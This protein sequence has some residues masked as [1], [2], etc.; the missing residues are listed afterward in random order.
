MVKYEIQ[1]HEKSKFIKNV[2]CILPTNVYNNKKLLTL[3]LKRLSKNKKDTFFVQQ[4]LRHQ[5]LGV[6]QKKK[7]KK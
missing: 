7:I 3:G 5:Y 4:K 2:C 1:K 6:L